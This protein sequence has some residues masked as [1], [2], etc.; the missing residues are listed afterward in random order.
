VLAIWRNDVS[1]ALL[2]LALIAAA[3]YLL[4]VICGARIVR[5][6]GFK[7]LNRRKPRQ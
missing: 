7:F 2:P 1:V 4:I 6:L 5:S 3:L